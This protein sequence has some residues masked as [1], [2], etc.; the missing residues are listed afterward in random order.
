MLSTARVTVRCSA[1]APPEEAINSPS[2]SEV[3]NFVINLS[4][5]GEQG[6]KQVERD[7]SGILQARH[8]TRIIGFSARHD[9]SLS[10]RQFGNPNVHRIQHVEAHRDQEK[11]ASNLEPSPVSGETIEVFEPTDGEGADRDGNDAA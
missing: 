9:A 11:A 10:N 4:S 1:I 2:A 6:P 8:V 7:R 5:G 3:G